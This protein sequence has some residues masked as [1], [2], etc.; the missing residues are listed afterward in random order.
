MSANGDAA[1]DAHAADLLGEV[2]VAGAADQPTADLFSG[3]RR[4]LARGI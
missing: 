3:Q 4:R 1:L 2:G